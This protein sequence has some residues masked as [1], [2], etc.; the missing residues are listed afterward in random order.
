M[1]GREYGSGAQGHRFSP[2]IDNAPLGSFQMVESGNG[3]IGID[4]YTFV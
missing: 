1:E 3:K 2:R 4:V